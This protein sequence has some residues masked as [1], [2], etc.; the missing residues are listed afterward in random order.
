MFRLNFNRIMLIAGLGLGIPDAMNFLP[1]RQAP[2]RFKK[3]KTGR[4]AYVGRTQNL[5]ADRSSNIRKLQ[6]S[7]IPL[8][9]PDERARKRHIHP[10]SKRS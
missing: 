4:K 8:M 2:G 6:R 1:I 7:P 10:R 3:M 5:I 9:E